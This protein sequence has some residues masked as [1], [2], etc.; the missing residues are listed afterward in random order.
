MIARVSGPWWSCLG[1]VRERVY[2]PLSA[3]DEPRHEV[4][5]EHWTHSE[6]TYAVN[7]WRVN[8]AIA[9]AVYA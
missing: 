2:R 3:Q 9:C 6:N 8:D 4:P 7:A 5:V 1:V